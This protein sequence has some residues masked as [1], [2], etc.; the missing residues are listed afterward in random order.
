M[1]EPVKIVDL[2]RDLVRLSGLS[3]NDIEIRYTGLRLG[4]KLYEELVLEDEV[5][6]KTHHRKIFIGRIKSCKFEEINAAIDDLQAV[7]DSSDA[8]RILQKL[9]SIVPEYQAAKLSIPAGPEAEQEGAVALDRQT[10]K[11][12]SPISPPRVAA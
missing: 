3:L 6:Q 1:G 9:K 2:A 8:G 10:V 7:A 11:G 5:A 12:D 4:E